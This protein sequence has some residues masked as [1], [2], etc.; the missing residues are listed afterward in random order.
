MLIASSSAIVGV[1]NSH[2]IARSDIPPRRNVSA[3]V[4]DVTGTR[5]VSVIS[6][7]VATTGSFRSRAPAQRGRVHRA[8]PVPLDFLIEQA[9]CQGCARHFERRG[10]V[11]DQRP[12]D[13]QALALEPL[14]RRV[15]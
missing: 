11:T 15:E 10:H 5:A 14:T 12:S 2:A 3:D 9:Q 13:P 6:M 7:L 1:M 8:V 4:A